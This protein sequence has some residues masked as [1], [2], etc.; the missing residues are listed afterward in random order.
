MGVDN[1]PPNV[2]PGQPIRASDINA[3][4][5][6]ARANARR[7]PKRGFVDSTG[8]YVRDAP[9]RVPADSFR[10]AKITAEDSDGYYEAEEVIWDDSADEWITKTD[11]VVWDGGDG[12]QPKVYE[13]N[14]T[15]GIPTD[16][17]VFIF[18]TVGDEGD[19]LPVF[20][21][22][23]TL[24]PG[25]GEGKVLQLDATATTGVPFFDYPRFT[26]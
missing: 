3:L 8:M 12:N 17:F 7:V 19:V 11:G 24:P 23:D 5:D 2:Q 13:I 18:N 1:L 26:S 6:I 22:G 4:L 10:T 20:I 14:G 16:W 9:P 25:V 21:T 15:A